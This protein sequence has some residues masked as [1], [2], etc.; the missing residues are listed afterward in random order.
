MKEKNLFLKEFEK[1]K[2]SVEI[3]SFH[4]IILILNSF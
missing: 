1:K 2:K 4:P 3:V